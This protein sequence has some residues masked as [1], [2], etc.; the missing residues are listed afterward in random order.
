MTIALALILLLAVYILVELWL[1]D[2]DDDPPVEHTHPLP[3]DDAYTGC[4]RIDLIGE[5]AC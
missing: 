3:A 2:A 5:T 4:H 1:A